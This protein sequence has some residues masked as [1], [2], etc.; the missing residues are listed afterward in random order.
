LIND[1]SE[2]E[3]RQQH[4]TLPSAPIINTNTFP[5]P[6]GDLISHD[7]VPLGINIYQL[8]K[9]IDKAF[10]ENDSGT[11]IGTR[12]IV[13]LY[14]GKLIAEKYAP[15]Y[16]INSKMLGW[17]MT[18]SVTTALIGIL[19]KE[20]RLKIDMPAPAPEWQLQNDRRHTITLENLLQQTSGL[21]FE[22]NYAK[23]SEATNML[24]K[25]GDMAAFTAKR[26]LKY[27]P[28][29]VFSYSSGNTNIL[30]PIIRQTVGEAQYHS[31]PAMKLFYKIG[32]YSAVIEPDAS[33]TFTGSS[34]MYATVRDWARFG[35]LYYNDGVWN[36]Q[37]ILPEGW[38][39][40]TSTPFKADSLK[41][42]GYQFWLNG[43]D[44]RNKSGRIYP[45]VPPDM[46]FADGFGGQNIYIIPSKKLVVVRLGLHGLNE[47]TFLKNIIACVPNN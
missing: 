46:Y 8:K 9:A 32:M 34:Y 43:F 27:K 39:K 47:N 11:T 21:Q 40:K 1:L 22:E 16:N 10:E 35:L 18:K 42:Y 31:F 45:D 15:G 6:L 29:S 23:A 3:I 19:V 25:K 41:H 36:G 12:A 20:G 38:V 14:D 7:S 28:G 33:G 4:F 17:S 2:K 26:P 30:S 13:V 44:K 37:R 24:F 5:W